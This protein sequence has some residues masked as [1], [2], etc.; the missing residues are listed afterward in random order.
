MILW[1]V[2]N[3]SL[4]IDGE[5]DPLFFQNQN[6]PWQ[7]LENDITLSISHRGKAVKERQESK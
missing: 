2:L 7:K 1:K 6:K 3:E 5:T 4:R